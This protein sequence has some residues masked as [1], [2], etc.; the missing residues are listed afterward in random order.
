M[1]GPRKR[2]W[3]T[4]VA[5]ILFALPLAY[6]ISFGPACGLIDRGVVPK[7]ALKSV[8]GPCYRLATG[9]IPYVAVVF[10]MWAEL[11]GHA[12]S[13]SAFE[14]IGIDLT[15]HYSGGEPRIIE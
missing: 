3:R 14:E 10:W 15:P 5:A 12:L 1:D 2:S 8:Y 9:G 13:D 4:W 7:S 11:F 6:F